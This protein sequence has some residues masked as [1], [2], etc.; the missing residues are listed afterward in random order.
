M[1]THSINIR[2]FMIADPGYLQCNF[3]LSMAEARILAIIAPEP[4]MLKVFSEGKDIYRDAAM[5][6]FKVSWEETSKETREG[7]MRRDKGKRTVLGANYKMGYQR[8]AIENG[9][10]YEEARFLLNGYLNTYPGVS[11]YWRWVENKLRNG[12]TLNNLALSENDPPKKR[13]FLGPLQQDTFNEA[14]SWLPQSSVA[15]I[16]NERAMK[17]I[18]YNQDLFSDVWLVSQEHDGFRFQFPLNR[19]DDLVRVI[20]FIRDELE[21]PVF[22]N[23]E[24]FRIPADFSFGYNVR[25]L[26]ELKEVGLSLDDSEVAEKMKELYETN[27]HNP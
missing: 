16:I 26:I 15:D 27:F 7:K 5:G 12:R 18:Y 19:W 11:E 20:R 17:F 14:F 6:I 1:T 9:I 24:G 4:R 23:G 3:D 10:E 8:F 25:D 21:K 2:R 13:L 22:W